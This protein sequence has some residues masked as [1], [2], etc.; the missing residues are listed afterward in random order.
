MV[1]KRPNIVN[2]V[3]ESPLRKWNLGQT[4]QLKESKIPPKIEKF[5]DFLL[6]ESLSMYT[7]IRPVLKNTIAGLPGSIKMLKTVQFFNM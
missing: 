1:K 4:N 3:C 2:V 6:F 5:L 7:K